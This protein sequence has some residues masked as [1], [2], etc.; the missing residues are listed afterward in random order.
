[1]AR[2][3]LLAAVAPGAI[4]SPATGVA[5]DPLPPTLVTMEVPAASAG[6]PTDRYDR[7]IDPSVG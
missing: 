4:V 3:V 1:M 5:P 2:R 6:G 7:Q